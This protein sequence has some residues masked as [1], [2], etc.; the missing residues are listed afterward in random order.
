MGHESEQTP[1]ERFLHR[2]LLLL[3]VLVAVGLGLF[4]ATRRLASSNDALRQRDAAE[5]LARG[6]AGLQRGDAP[7]ALVSLRKAAHIDRANREIAIAL[8]TALERSGSRSEAIDVLESLRDLRPDDADIN[9]ELARLAAARGDLTQAIRD[10]QDALD[11]LWSPS[12]SATSRAVRTEFIALL[13]SHGERARALSQTLVLGADGLDTPAELLEVA[14]LLREAGDPRRALDRYRRVLA[15]T[16]ANAA[17][18]MGAGRAAFDLG[19]YA[20]ARSY[21]D[22]VPAL[23][24]DA[25]ELREVAALVVSADPLAP[26]LARGERQARRSRIVEQALGRLGACGGDEPQRRAVADALTALQVKEP[27][28]A[29][30]Q[31]PTDELERSEDAVELAARAERLADRCGT[32]NALDRAIGLIARA[33]GVEEPR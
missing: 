22:R 26:R 5:W 27:T 2:E 8:S 13:L 19:D 20:A 6:R 14:G 23:E 31:P 12:V 30:G 15:S 1:R 3:L 4:V 24:A 18:L 21:F 32:A 10:Y 9:V 25:R 28:R 11:A 33:H 7:T 29:R 16:P 17:A